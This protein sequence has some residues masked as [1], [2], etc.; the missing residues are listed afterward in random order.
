MEWWGMMLLGKW[1]YLGLWTRT[2][3]W[4]GQRGNYEGSVCSEDGDTWMSLEKLILGPYAGLGG[5]NMAPKLSA[6]KYDAGIQVEISGLLSVLE[7][8]MR[9][10]VVAAVTEYKKAQFGFGS[11]AIGN[12]DQNEKFLNT[13]FGGGAGSDCWGAAALIHGRGL[14]KSLWAGEFDFLGGMSAIGRF[15]RT[16][17]RNILNKGNLEELQKSD[18]GNLPLQYL[19][20][21]RGDWGAFFGWTKSPHYSSENV[22]NVGKDS[23]FGHP[24]GDKSEDQWFAT[25]DQ[26][27]KANWGKFLRTKAALTFLDV[28]WIAWKLWKKRGGN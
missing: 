17:N 4:S 23:W 27:G 11:T 5:A 13:C 7:R 15:G 3:M 19:D 1:D 26:K 22:I 12:P 8:K 28:D 10:N 16:G 2:A 24:L 18:G 21:R 9:D 20:A 25:L 6:L 14:Q